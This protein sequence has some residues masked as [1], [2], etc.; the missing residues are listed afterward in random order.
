M[1][2][3]LLCE[4]G[5]LNSETWGSRVVPTTRKPAVTLISRHMA[6]HASVSGYDRLGHYLEARIIHPVD[7][8]TFARRT[9]TRLLRPLV[10]RSGC[11]W[12]HRDA[13]FS[14]LCAGVHWLKGSNRLFHFLYGENAYRYLGHLKSVARKN[15]LVCTF[16]TPEE[17]FRAVVRDVRHLRRIDAAIV[18]ST[19][20]LDFFGNLL[21]RDRVHYVPHGIDVDY[22][23]PLEVSEQRDEEVFRCLFVGTHLRD[24]ESLAACWRIVNQEAKKMQL[25]V[26]TF[27]EYHGYFEGIPNVELYAGIPDQ[28]LL[29]LYRGAHAF[30][31]PLLDSTANNSLLEAM[32]CGLPVVCSDVP[33]VRDYAD[34]SCTLFT[35]RGDA[36][37]MAHAVLTLNKNRRLCT[38]MGL[39]ARERVMAFGWRNVAS[40]VMELYQGL[41]G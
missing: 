41:A 20:Q 34:E 13:L 24:F 3:I 37:A 18:V 40:M 32:A 9:V 11:L 25:S 10:H 12:Y 33:G 23:R 22:F 5:R 7:Q 4:V 14:E 35:A 28:K 2:G 31:F 26:V 8:W 29:A 39:A 27:P 17:K 30:V 15:L 19:S 21:G 1:L 36:E 6:N 16:H 38:T